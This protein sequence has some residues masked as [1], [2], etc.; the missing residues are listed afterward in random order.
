M[1]REWCAVHSGVMCEASL[2]GGVAIRAQAGP[3][4]PY[5]KRKEAVRRLSIWE[6]KWNPPGLHLMLLCLVCME[7]CVYG[8]NSKPAFYRQMF[9]VSVSHHVK[10]VPFGR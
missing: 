10:N 9:L 7:T 3:L 1:A 4:V 8:G 5:L 6:L 2:A